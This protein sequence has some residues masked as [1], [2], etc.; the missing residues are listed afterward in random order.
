MSMSVLAPP[1]Y[2][3]SQDL[4]L[5]FFTA[6]R[7][8]VMLWSCVRL[9]VCLSVTVSGLLKRLNIGSHKQNHAIAKDPR[10]IP[11]GSLPVCLPNARGVGQ[12]LQ[13]LT[14]SFS[15]VPPTRNVA[16]K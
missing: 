10:E 3:T 5:V 2:S 14:S 16:S 6:R 7:Y 8:A 12:N 13:L 15:S 11:P 4:T 9:S 1:C